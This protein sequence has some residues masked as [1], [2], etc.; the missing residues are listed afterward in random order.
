VAANTASTVCI[1]LGEQAPG[2]LAERDLAARLVTVDGGVV[3]LGGWPEG[4]T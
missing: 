3:R 2:W 4:G 1:V